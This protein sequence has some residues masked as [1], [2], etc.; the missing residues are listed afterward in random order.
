MRLFLPNYWVLLN[1]NIPKIELELYE[2]G[3]K[4]VEISVQEGLIDVGIICTKPQSKEFDSF[5][6][7]SDPLHIIL[8]KES[9]LAA[10]SELSLSQLSNESFVLYK[11]DF[12]LHDEIVKSCKQAGFQPKII[13]ETS[14][15]DLMLQTVAAD[16]AVALLPSRLCPKEEDNTKIS[17]N[18]VVR[19]LRE[20]RITHT[21][22]II[23]KH[24]HYLS[25]ASQLW[26]D[27]VRN[28]LHSLNNQ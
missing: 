19:P 1:K 9:P 5:F 20:P 26:L 12:N 2:H 10:H 27:F 28:R 18:V 4:K 13:F 6:L 11:D 23:W 17:Q 3:S 24:S 7:T 15:R 22:Y 21:L 8:P 25:H 16:L 14:Q